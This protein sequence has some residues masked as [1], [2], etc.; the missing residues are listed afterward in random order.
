MTWFDPKQTFRFCSGTEIAAS[1]AEI[2]LTFAALL[3]ARFGVSVS[4]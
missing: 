4:P 2:V 1:M 3:G